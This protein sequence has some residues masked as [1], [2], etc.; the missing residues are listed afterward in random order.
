MGVYFASLFNT[1]IKREERSGEKGSVECR[2]IDLERG[3]S[4]Q[5][6]A[7]SLL[8]LTGVLLKDSLSP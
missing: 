1:L 3:S 2:A 7:T 5:Q 6:P 4:L 8:Q